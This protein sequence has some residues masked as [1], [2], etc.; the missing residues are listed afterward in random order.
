MKTGQ[1]HVNSPIVLLSPVEQPPFL[2]VGKVS[3]SLAHKKPA[4]IERVVLVG[5]LKDHYA[6]LEFY[7]VFPLY[8]NEVNMHLATIQPI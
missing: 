2:A 4:Q 1:I 5:F 3:V 7:P 8:K 6:K